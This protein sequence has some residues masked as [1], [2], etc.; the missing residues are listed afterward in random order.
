MKITKERKNIFL[1]QQP[2]NFC[3][4]FCER[5]GEV[6]NSCRMHSDDV[7]FKMR[8]LRENKDPNDPKVAFEHISSTLD[9]VLGV[10]KER[11]EE[12]GIELDKAEVSEIELEELAMDKKIEKYP[13]YKKCSA[14]HNEL[15]EFLSD[16]DP[17]SLKEP[18]P[19]MK[20][21]WMAEMEEL[22][23]YSSMIFIKAQRALLSLEGGQDETEL[24]FEDASISAALGYF[25]LLT[26]EKSLENIRTLI[27]KDEF[28]WTMKINALLV[29][30]QAAKTAYQKSFPQVEKFKNKIIFHGRH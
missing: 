11:L 2:F 8:C 26:V 6:K 25:S 28:V 19:W 16:F 9:N 10:L 23:F 3:D 22:F 4:R 24:E 30:I 17:S 14:V 1:K 7:Q 12:E 15:N 20:K 27:L 29:K 18:L 5:C 13:L 21:F